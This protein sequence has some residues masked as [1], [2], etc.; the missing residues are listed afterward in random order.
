MMRLALRAEPVRVMA[1]AGQVLN[2]L[3]ESYG[4]EVPDIW[5]AGYVVV[6]FDSGA[7]AMLELCMFAEG[8]RYQEE[9]SAVGP[10][11]KIECFVPGPGRFWA[12]EDAAPVAKLV[13]SPRHPVGPRTI[14]LPVEAGLLAVGDHNGAT[15]YQHQ[16]FLQVVRGLEQPE[17]S[18]Q[19]GAKAVAM[20]M[21]AQ[22]SARTGLAVT[23]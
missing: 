5:D 13:L 11:G 10:T 9:I 14:E 23:L 22:E 8:S 18:R 7:R 16:R 12:G 4:G 17:V 15:F 2:H 19:D 1:S 6:D 21:A 20:G 3:D